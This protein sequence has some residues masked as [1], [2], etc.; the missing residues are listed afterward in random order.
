MAGHGGAEI[1]VRNHGDVRDHLLVRVLV[2]LRQLDHAVEHEDP[3]VS[4]VDGWRA[5]RAEG[6]RSGEEGRWKKG[7]RK[8]CVSYH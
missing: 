7:E 6:S 4:S 1:V 5:K 3:P 8:G 2:A